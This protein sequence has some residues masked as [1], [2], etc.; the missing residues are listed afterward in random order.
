M[1]YQIP[2]LLVSRVFKPVV[3][4]SD[5]VAEQL[6][7]SV[8][9]RGEFQVLF[10][11]LLSAVPA[12]AYLI[13]ERSPAGS[14]DPIDDQSTR[15]G[16]TPLQGGFRSAWK[17]IGVKLEIFTPDGE[18]F[19]APE[20]T[21]ADLKKFQDLRGAPTGSWSYIIAGEKKHIFDDVNESFLDE[22]RG[23]LKITV[24]ETVPS[25]S[26]PFLVPHTPLGFAGKSFSFDLF[27]VGEF[28]A[29]VRQPALARWSG[30]MRL[31][32]PDGLVA[33]Q[34]NKQ[35][36]RFPV[37]LPTLNKSRDNLGRPRNW[38]LE[39]L[40]ERSHV[41]NVSVSATVFGRGQITIATLKTRIDSLLGP[42][43]AFV[44]LFGENKDGNAMARLKVTDPVSAETIDMHGLLDHQ[45]ESVGQDDGINAR[46]FKPNTVYTLEKKPDVRSGIK[47]DVSTLKVST[48]D[49]AI[50]PGVLLGVAVP[51]IR[52]SI[53]VLG[54]VRVKFAGQTLATAKLRGGK[55]DVE[56]GIKLSPENEP[57]LVSML[58]DSPFDFDIDNAVLATALVSPL[59]TLGV[60]TIV[61]FL[62]QE[63][64]KAIVSCVKTLFTGPAL[65]PSILMTLFG[66]HL[67]YRSIRI[68]GEAVVFDFI[69]PLEPEP[70]PNPNY[71][72]AIGRETF[73]QTGLGSPAFMPLIGNTWAADNLNSK[74]DHIVVVM[75]ENRS[76]DHV[77][78][79]RARRPYS[80]GAD[81]LTEAMVNKIEAAPNGRF[82]VRPMRDAGF[83]GNP[84]GLK[85]RLPKGVGHETH[86]VEQQLHAQ[87]TG[88]DG[89]G[90]INSPEGFT[91]NFEPKLALKPGDLPHG[92][93]PNDVLGF[94]EPS[95]LPFYGYLAENY[96]YCDR[97][98]CSHPGP[99][100]PNRMFSLTGDLQH[101][102]YGFP[103][104]DNNT[105]DNFLL[106]RAPTIYDM[107][108]RKGISWR[109]YESAPS[110]SMLRMFARYATNNTDILPLGSN[111]DPFVKLR[112]DVATNNLPAFTTIEP[113][114]H[115]HPQNDDHPDADMYRGQIF[116][117]EVYN[118]LR[119]N[120][121]TWK[122][123]LLIVTYDEHGG[124]YDHVIPPLADFYSAPITQAQGGGDRRRERPGDIVLGG[125]T[126][127]TT[128]ENP[129]ASDATPPRGATSLKVHYGVRV[130]TFVISPWT[131]PGKGP[132]ITL[133]HCSILKTVLAR[134][135]GAEKP[136]LSDRVNAS[137]SFNSFL[138][139]LAP[140][141]NVP[142]PPQLQTNFGPDSRRV[143][144]G[145]S[146]IVTPPLSRQAMR[147]GPV[148]YHSLSGSVARMLGR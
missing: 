69:A 39:V 99:T 48:I 102:R 73:L 66:A 91:A 75:M 37:N 90:V 132:S 68:E 107:L 148:D 21:I 119:S 46:D 92:V 64:N 96:A 86:D 18:K 63:I 88:P 104:L 79:Y 65:A 94:Y 97:Y 141:M 101:D 54:E 87:T 138:T 72:G 126:P 113:A 4:A 100:L 70:K 131:T 67:K 29:E 8:K 24:V 53:A 78:G 62:E 38:Q 52:L 55:T 49:L 81:G 83:D 23:G 1:P 28:V 98:Y 71:G 80:D 25:Q 115:H 117:Q 95:D 135:L 77:L 6:T 109:V 34:T 10:P 116:L 85:T 82:V 124:L 35:V 41:G 147:D 56:L 137:Q 105:G 15:T 108:T 121:D 130:P 31:I 20:I 112:R 51:A 103:I 143:A 27:R 111:D 127:T 129:A 123:T 58:A 74:V 118:T 32:S 16:S 134:F 33:A 60:V 114:M 146:A 106:S 40:P 133:D 84:F 120:P 59:V 14:S 144:P 42:R 47:I 26:A 125:Q 61:E 139:G 12:A 30:I 17:P 44:Q 128:S 142:A 9:L 45:L 7:F 36:L 19:A 136:F 50:G 89:Y 11:G 110:V 13:R 93:V 3:T 145:A 122:K 76:Y 140:R 2:H 43:G 5:L 57:Y 22:V